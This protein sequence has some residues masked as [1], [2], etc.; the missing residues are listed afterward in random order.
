MVVIA[1]IAILASLLFPTVGNA[2]ERARAGNCLSNLK[3]IA[4]AVAAEAD[5]NRGRVYLYSESETIDTSWA[6]ELSIAKAAGGQDVFLCPSYPPK[7]FNENGFK[8]TTTYGVRVDP[9]G[10]YTESPEP[11]T[12]YLVTQR[13]ESPADYLH[14]ADTTSVGQD[15]ITAAQYKH[16]YSIAGG[17]QVHARHGNVANGLFLDGHA[18][19]CGR[20][21]LEGL[22]ITAIYG[23]D[24]EGGYYF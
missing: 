23:E 6:T 16:F 24:T 5:D 19:P 17:P 1:I 9:P 12:T 13:V 10:T 21:R 3:Q 4:A 2:L 15:G 7:V 11:G 14:V 22:G 8:W 18:E 20:E